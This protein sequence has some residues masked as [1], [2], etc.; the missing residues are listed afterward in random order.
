[1]KP[2]ICLALAATL[3]LGLH[4]CEASLDLAV[5]GWGLSL[6]NSSRIIGVRVNAVDDGVQSVTGLNLTL[7]NPRR[8]PDAT[9]Y[10]ATIGLIGP[11]AGRID[12]LA[13]GGLG[14]V[15]HE[16]L[17]G[18]ALAGFGVG[19][20]YLRGIAG[21]LILVDAKQNMQ[22]IGVAGYSANVGDTSTG[23]LLAGGK[24]TAR[25]ST[26]LLL[27][28]I[29][30]EAD[31]VTGIVAGG[32][33]AGAMKS[34]DGLAV[35]LGCAYLMGRQAQGIVIG[36]LLASTGRR[37]TGS[38]LSAGIVG[39]GGQA[40]GLAV[41]GI[42]TF[43]AEGMSGVALSLGGVGT[44]G[45]LRGIS[46]AGV[47]TVAGRRISGLCLGLGGVGAGERITG[48]ALGGLT[49]LSKEVRGVATGALNGVVVEEINLENFLKLRTINER[50]TGVSVGLFNYTGRLRGVQI[51]L[52]NYAANNPRWLRLLPIVNAHL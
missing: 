27:G 15:A 11:K 23:V 20:N 3:L 28:G 16:R 42:G 51:G 21:G 47:A 45:D 37:F 52:L 36:G 22:G 44:G 6:G 34:F 18:I 17:R 40:R 13:L 41:G 48:V 7:W 32:L 33:G 25:Q 29:L 12:G 2:H 5:S 39:L 49:C 46:L 38:A 24:A 30:A 19:T 10:G 31:T 50:F 43:A 9:V 14:A 35:S 26:G 8:N 1:M 4:P